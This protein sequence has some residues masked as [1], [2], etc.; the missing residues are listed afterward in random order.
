[1]RRPLGRRIRRRGPLNAPLT[2]SDESEDVRWFSLD[3]LP[4]MTPPGWRARAQHVAREAARRAH[5]Q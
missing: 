2:V 3:D 5:R 1:M 4:E